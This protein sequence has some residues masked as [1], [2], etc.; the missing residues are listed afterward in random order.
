MWESML[1]Q[2]RTQINREE[3]Y[4]SH[5]HVLRKIY[6]KHKGIA[7]I[8]SQIKCPIYHPQCIDAK[9]DINHRYY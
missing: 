4:I 5:E 8:A 7:Q 3:P 6:L 2:M 9:T 1:S